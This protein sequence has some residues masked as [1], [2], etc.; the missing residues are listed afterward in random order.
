[1]DILNF[2]ADLAEVIL[3]IELLLLILVIAAVCAGV[4]FGVWWA[5]SRVNPLFARLNGYIS[6]GQDYERTGLRMAVKPLIAIHTVGECVA[7]TLRTLRDSARR[8]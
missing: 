8:S 5:E 4:A 7:V 3:T 1:M 2:F 6:Q